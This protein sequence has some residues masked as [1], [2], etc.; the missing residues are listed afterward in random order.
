MR[1]KLELTR[2]YYLIRIG[3][4]WTKII[5]LFLGKILSP[6]ALL[7]PLI[8]DTSY[9]AVVEA[10]SSFKSTRSFEDFKRAIKNK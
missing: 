8:V 4:Y 7:I 1:V 2:T 3:F 10:K 6:P 9:W 5:L